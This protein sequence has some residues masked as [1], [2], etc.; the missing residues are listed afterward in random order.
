MLPEQDFS[1]SAA[2]YDLIWVQ[3]VIGHLHDIDCVQF[4]RRCAAGL[5]PSGV[6]VLKDNVLIDDDLTFLWDRAD[7][8]VARH[9]R[10]L[11]LLISLSGLQVIMEARQQDF[12]S[13]LLPV[14]MIAISVA[15]S[16]LTDT[17][18]IFL[19]T[20]SNV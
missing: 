17:P 9:M 8:S 18:S 12:P 4:F 20:S 15:P 6:I 11:Q 3:W 1:P 13:E 10:Y 5:K 16:L 7:S 2:T 19:S 14:F